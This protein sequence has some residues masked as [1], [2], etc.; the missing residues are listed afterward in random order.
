[1]TTLLQAEANRRNA[2]HSTGPRTPEGKAASSQNHFKHGLY[3]KQLI[4]AGENSA[5]LDALKADLIAEHK[6]A[7]T[8]EAL[9]SNPLGI[10]VTDVNW[11][12]LPGEPHR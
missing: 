4:I 10:F 12:S 2:Q 11:T 6:P 3:S 9:L 7:T 5:D 1:M 8:T